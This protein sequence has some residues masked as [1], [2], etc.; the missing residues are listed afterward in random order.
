M[1]GVKVNVFSV[2]A[3]AG[4][5]HRTHTH[6]RTHACPV[7]YMELWGESAARLK[8]S[9]YFSVIRNP[10]PSLRRPL[11]PSYFCVGMSETQRNSP[12]GLPDWAGNMAQSGSFTEKYKSGL[13]LSRP[14]PRS[15]EGEGVSHDELGVFFF[16]PMIWRTSVFFQM[17]HGR[18]ESDILFRLVMDHSVL[19]TQRKVGERGRLPGNSDESLVRNALQKAGFR[20]SSGLGFHSHIPLKFVGV[21]FTAKQSYWRTFPDSNPLRFQR[22]LGGPVSHCLL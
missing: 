8:P 9:L 2:R 21:F 7:P 18:D 5:V 22:D 17:A 6:T 11:E 4:G 1:L 12:P 15:A 13:T 19:R 16:L 14:P 20:L 3:G 10:T